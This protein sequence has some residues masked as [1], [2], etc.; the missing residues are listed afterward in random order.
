MK[1]EYKTLGDYRDLCVALAGEDNRAVRFLDKR[2]ADQGRDMDVWADETQMI[3][4]L[5]PMLME[6]K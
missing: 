1:G 2:I 5:G 6:K 3:M 4:L